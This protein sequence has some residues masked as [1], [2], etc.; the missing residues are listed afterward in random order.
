MSLFKRYKPYW[1]LIALFWLLA[2]GLYL[3]HLTMGFTPNRVLVRVAFLNLDLYWYGFLIM[4]GVALGAWVVSDLAEEQGQK[5]MAAEV[6]ALTRDQPLSSLNDLPVI[7]TSQKSQTIGQFLL[8]WGFDPQNIAPTPSARQQ[9]HQWLQNQTSL[10]PQWWQNPSWRKWNPDHVWNGVIWCMI[11]AVIGARLYHVFT[12]SPSMAALGIHSPWDYFQHP[13]Q[14]LN[15]RN[16]GLG[17]YGGILGGWLGLWIYTRRQQVSTLLWADLG[18][19]GVALGQTV[20]RW[21]NFFNQELYGRPSNLPWAV[22]IDP[23]YR[24][25][26]YEEVARFHPAFLYESLWN[27]GSFLILYI[28]FKR[29]P[30]RLKSGDLTAL[31]LILYAIG[32]ILLELTRLDSRML[33]LGSTPTNLPVATAISLVTIIIMILWRSLSRIYYP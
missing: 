14:L 29:Y 26:G 17:I 10:Q 6:P 16:G 11:F 21:G 19:I 13:M 7:L 15:L 31:Y 8:R 23:P 30:H 20:G 25:A 5:E 12:P 33:T 3:A 32:R 28:L 9:I 2:G 18:A 22:T 24:L 27:F 4:A 1:Y